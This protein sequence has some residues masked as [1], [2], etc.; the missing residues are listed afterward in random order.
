M[1]PKEIIKRLETLKHKA[2]EAHSLCV[3][4]D[5][6]LVQLTG[7]LILAVF[8]AWIVNEVVT[9]RPQLPFRIKV[10]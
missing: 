4:I 2:E 10:K 9:I 7:V 8:A 6:G 3:D 5:T 1:T